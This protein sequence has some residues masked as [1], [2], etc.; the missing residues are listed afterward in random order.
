[1]IRPKVSVI[2]PVYNAGR[3]LRDCLDTIISQSLKDIE[4]IC[5]N[6]GSTDDSAEILAHYQ[7]QDTRIRIVTQENKGGANARN[8]GMDIAEGEYLSF[9]DADDYFDKDMLK[10]AAEQ[11]DET[12]AEVVI[13]DA[14]TVNCATG[15]IG[16]PSWIL[17]Q[18]FI[19][20]LKV[21]SKVDIPDT[22]L[23]LSACCVWN[24][25]Y[26][27]KKI[28]KENIRFQPLVSADDTFFSVMAL[29]LAQRVTILNKRLM[30]YRINNS[31]GQQSGRTKNPLNQYIAFKTIK[32]G[33][34]QR[35]LF[36]MLEKTFTNRA[37]GNTLV[38][39]DAMGT[40]KAFEFLF[41]YTRTE[42][43]KNFKFDQREKEYFYSPD[44]YERLQKI[45]KN[46]AAE[47]LFRDY[48]KLRNQ[49]NDKRKIM[50]E[51]ENEIV[52]VFI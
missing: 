20:T 15:T 41:D 2:V 50:K 49:L 51:T 17:E 23:Q 8:A 52:G 7:Q 29:V 39:L 24:K 12:N 37:A 40:G 28:Q 46:T 30:H 5:V 35:S 4:I 32:E 34:E 26:L 38:N 9:L 13:F 19:P 16:E 3:Y 11:A 45:K 18:Q 14:Y 44:I 27:R 47:Y 10:L 48:E 31:T 42:I 22:I 33:L 36:D 6:D 1:M 21:F 43:F 25:L